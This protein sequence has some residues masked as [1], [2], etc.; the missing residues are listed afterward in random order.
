[1]NEQTEPRP[2]PIVSIGMPVY[3]G[4]QY[5]GEALDSLLAQ[6]FTDFELIISDNASTDATETV[7][8]EYVARD[9]RVRYYRQTENVGAVDNFRFVLE[10]AVGR[11]FMWAAHDD[12]WCPDFISACVSALQSNDE[13]AFA[14]TKYR[15]I[16]RFF[17]LFSR[18]SV[19]DLRLV[20][21]ADRKRRV[22]AYSRM[23]FHTHK[24]N[25]LYSLWNRRVLLG[26]LG[27]VKRI[28]KPNLINGP[29]LY[30]ALSLHRGAFVNKVLFEKKYRYAVSGHFLNPVIDGLRSALARLSGV[31]EKAGRESRPTAEEIQYLDDLVAVL[32]LA[33]FDETFVAEVLAVHAS[34][35]RDPDQQRLPAHA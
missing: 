34:Y 25:L 17:F 11:Y 32:A 8:R 2:V 19:P 3:N 9:Q 35:V 31:P 21:D 5:V 6:T 33:G 28:G 18:L 12:F 1:M 26:L 23:P 14:V 16:S 24:D 30:Y 27:N 22:L 10:K 7:C 15:I 20:T 29:M 13:F 4:A